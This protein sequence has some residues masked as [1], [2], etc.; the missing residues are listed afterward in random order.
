M[1]GLWADSKAEEAIIMPERI[2]SVQQIG[3][4][5]NRITEK[6]IKPPSAGDCWFCLFQSQG[7]KPLG[8]EIGD[9]SHLIS[10]IREMHV[11]G[12]LIVN[13]CRARGRTDMFLGIVFH[14]PAR[15]LDEIRDDLK[16]Y[17]IRELHQRGPV[18]RKGA[19]KGGT[20]IVSM[21]GKGEPK[22]V[23]K[24]ARNRRINRGM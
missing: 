22:V 7:G 18:T 20:I 15:W 6:H 19:S 2:P 14:D 13:A 16:K 11:P 21:R 5:A 12:S 23:A 3:K 1:V 17:L 8:E 10:H 24:N 4:F 9:K